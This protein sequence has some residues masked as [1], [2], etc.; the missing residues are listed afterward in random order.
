MSRSNTIL[1][2]LLPVLISLCQAQSYDL[3]G[4]WRD[5]LGQTMPV[6]QIGN[7]VYWSLDARPHAI[8]VFVG[9]LSENTISGKWADLP[10]G[11]MQGGGTLTLRVV[12]NGRFVKVSESSGPYAGSVWERVGGGGG[13]GGTTGGGCG[14]G[15]RW[16]EKESNW[17]LLWT[18]RGDSNVFDLTTLS[19]PGSLTAV[20]TVVLEGNRVLVDRGTSS[21]GNRC[22]MQGTMSGAQVKG[23]YDCFGTHPAQNIPWSAEIEC[24]D[25]AGTGGAGGQSDA[26]S[27]ECGLGVFWEEQESGWE[28][29]WARRGNSNLFD[30]Y[31]QKSHLRLTAAQTVTLNGSRVLAVRQSSSDGN[32]CEFEGEMQGDRHTVKGTYSCAGTHPVTGAAWQAVIRC[33]GTPP[34]PPAA[35]APVASGI[36]GDSGTLA[37]MD[38]WLARAIPPQRP[39]DRLRY[40]AWGRLVGSTQSAVI[41]AAAPPD[42]RMTRCEWLWYYSPGLEATNGLGTLREYVES[43]RP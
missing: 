6:R 15:R 21:D 8:N 25:L 36:C 17:H 13:E 34:P 35:T 20:Q 37:I 24:G 22:R 14:L 31:G 26:S 32:V 3:T 33:S 42:T 1:I 16:S 28:M 39:G 2:V 19:G 9:T 10:G 40:D 38:E 11:Q 30:V 43:R 23:T 4:I 29:T 18:R 27:S 12:S 5:E 41:A 7:T